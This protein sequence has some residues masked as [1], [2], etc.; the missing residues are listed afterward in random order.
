MT[1]VPRRLQQGDLDLL[2]TA[3]RALICAVR[4]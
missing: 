1:A 2:M 3:C 4:T